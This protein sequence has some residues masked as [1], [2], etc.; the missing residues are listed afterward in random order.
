MLP[1][2]QE[3]SQ[4]SGGKKSA[5]FKDVSG[6]NQKKRKSQPASCFIS[7]SF[8]LGELAI[9]VAV[10]FIFISVNNVKTKI[11]KVFAVYKILP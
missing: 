11:P 5:Y 10:I 3:S 7:V 4:F 8:N 1:L 6:K 2:L 9:T